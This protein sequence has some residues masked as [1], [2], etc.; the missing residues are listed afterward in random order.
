M[1]DEERGR[2]G[3]KRLIGEGVK[4]GG[5]RERERDAVSYF[6]PVH[7]ESACRRYRS[8]PSSPGGGAQARLELTVNIQRVDVVLFSILGAR[9]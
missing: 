7:A 4:G 5:V 8:R 1:S 9:M 3:V 2:R 6:L